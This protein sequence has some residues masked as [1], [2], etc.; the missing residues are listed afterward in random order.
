MNPDMM[1]DELPQAPAGGTSG[2]DVAVTM[3][4]VPAD[5]YDAVPKMGDVMPAGTFHF[6]LDR[7]SK[8]SYEDGPVYS[9]TWRCQEEPHTGRVVFANCP[10]PK[11]SDVALANDP[12]APKGARAEAQKEVSKR[13]V[14]SKAIQEAAGIRPGS[15]DFEEFLGTNPEVKITERV[16]GKK[17]LK[18]VADAMKGEYVNDAGKVVDKA[19]QLLFEDTGEQK[20]I[21]VKYL[22][23]ARPQ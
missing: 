14:V 13:L 3:A 8:V 2:G 19:G 17:A 18:G 22:S 6:R 20:N 1:E 15:M 7:Y 9:L 21:V 5:M 23:L 12:D 11:A 16:T 10:W 4:S